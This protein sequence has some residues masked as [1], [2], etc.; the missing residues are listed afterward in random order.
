MR[1]A[2]YL[3]AAVLAAGVTYV[4]AQM[5]QPR[6]VPPPGRPPPTAALAVRR[7]DAPADALYP[8]PWGD[9]TRLQVGMRVVAIG[10]PF[11]LE[12]TLTTGIV[13]SL[14]R[15]MRSEFN[16]RAR[17]IRGIIQTDAAINPGN[18]G[19]PLLNRRGEMVGITAAII[20]RA[21][22]S[23]GVGMAVPANTARRVVAELIEHGRVIRPDCGILSVYQLDDGLLVGR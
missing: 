5:G 21:G 17:L 16:D 2:S 20:S 8:L 4:A 7:I 6:P 14:N 22:Q 1:Y 11:G 12:R 13:S 15:S 9:S 3:A 18:S 19:G 23:S 10:N